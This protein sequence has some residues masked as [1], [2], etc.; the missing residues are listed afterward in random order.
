M[1]TV[2]SC[3]FT[4]FYTLKFCESLVL[5]AVPDFYMDL[6]FKSRKIS[7]R[8]RLKKSEIHYSIILHR[9]RT[10]HYNQYNNITCWY[11]YLAQLK[12]QVC[13]N[14]KG[15]ITEMVKDFIIMI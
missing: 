6:V 14:V 11:M 12:F 9:Y 13:T 2:T 7:T 15:S 4:L 8:D 5:L 1:P 10:S 3:I